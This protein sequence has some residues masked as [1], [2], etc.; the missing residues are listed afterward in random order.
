MIFGFF[1]PQGLSDLLYHRV[2][3]LRK[4]SMSLSC[5][6]TAYFAC[7][8][9]D[10]N[11]VNHRLLEDIHRQNAELRRRMEDVQ[12]ATRARGHVGASGDDEEDGVARGGAMPLVSGVHALDRPSSGYES[13]LV[14]ICIET[15]IC[16]KKSLRFF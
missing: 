2:W 7:A 4:A 13:G 16:F 14:S 1:L 12:V 9:V 3:L 10:Y 5:L 8:F 6:V 15:R 11:R